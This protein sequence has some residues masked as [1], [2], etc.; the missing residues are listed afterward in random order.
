[1]DSRV[2]RFPTATY[3]LQL[4]GQLRFEKVG[5]LADYL[6]ELGIGAAYLS[7][8]FRAR[9]GSTHGYDVVDHRQPDPELGTEEDFAAMAG[10]L[11]R[12]GMGLMV[13]IVPNHMG[14]DDPH[15]VWWQDVL[16]NGPSSI[17]AKYFD[18][19]WNP[20]K[21]ALRGKV[22]LPAL[23][24]QFGKVL[25]E[26]QLRLTYED[27]RLVVR[28]YDRT[29]PTD[30]Q[31][32]VPLL[33]QALEFVGTRLAPEVEERME[34]ESIITAL[35]HLPRRSGR[36]AEL[37]Q[38]R[39]RETEVARRRLSTLMSA[40]EDVRLGVEQAIEDY[41]GQR[42]VSASFD[43]LES[44]LTEQA[45]RLCYWRV[46]TD[47][48]NYRRFFDVDA[49]AA[50]R[51]EEPEVFEAVHE[52]ILR[53]I[54]A[55][56]VTALRIDHADGLFD[57]QQ[58]LSDLADAVAGVRKDARPSQ[59]ASEGERLYTVVEKILAYDESLPSDWPVH[60]TTGYDFLNLLGGIFVDRLGAY[61]LRD[62]YARFTERSDTFRDVL[63]QSKRTILATSLSAELYMLSQ[64][65]D[66]ISEQHRWSRDFT[67][68]SLF[69]ALREV[70]TCFPVY[71]TYIRPESGEVREEDRR[72]ILEAI[73][74]AKRRNPAMSPSFFDFIAAV[75]LLEEPEGLSE[76]D[77]RERQRFVRKFQQFTG[78]VTAKGLEDTSFY[79]YFPL[80]SLNEVGGDPSLPGISIEQ[81]HRRIL[82]QSSSWPHSMLASGTH[83]TKRGED[84]RARL[85]VLAEIPDAWE[86][87]IK[88]WHAMNAGSRCELDGAPVPDANEEYL[89]YQTL[90]GSWPVEMPDEAGRVEYV[91]RIVHYLDK[92]LRE[93][94][95]HTS[96]LNPYEE[97]DQGVA[98]FIRSILGQLDTPFAN[99]VGLFAR[100]IAEAGF[101]NSLAQTLVKMCAPGVPDVYQ[102][103]EFWDF[104]LVDP[105]NR[106]PVDFD[107]RR[108]ALRWLQV[109]GREGLGDVAAELMARWPD[110]RLK[111]FMIWQ[112][113]QHRGSHRSLLEGTYQPLFAEGPRKAQLCA[114]ARVAQ[115]DWALCIV[116]RLVYQATREV[117]ESNG[118]SAS[119]SWALASWW[120]DTHLQLPAEA[121]RRWRHVLTGHVIDA[122]DTPE[123]G[124]TLDLAQV[125]RLFPVALLAGEIT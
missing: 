107:C 52:T 93:A 77:R 82:E 123:G 86:A 54:A 96:W 33:R 57:P 37:L 73:R 62:I 89:I 64:R 70:V 3:R 9:H 22:L 2:T 6:S 85:N 50:I 101:V 12:Q 115:T 59:A 108:K 110:K 67:R 61:A 36:T 117:E 97:Y 103:V 29:F 125:L 79:R 60:G 113:L 63:H 15:N 94:K 66:R 51:V 32:W 88:R 102:G 26:Q 55:G 81:F 105:D 27:Q 78:P 100:S 1:V 11:R 76:D 48:I 16:E 95:L 13:D 68:F 19:D 39:H 114:F 14:I 28:Y 49:L 112:S 35:E 104:N 106:R 71:R 47:E 92:A 83:D 111:L 56:W 34:L 119:G 46:A 45:Y 20:P 74:T 8:F 24:D 42:G 44:L 4:S 5:E 122:V 10:A 21:E 121:P 23:G 30:P 118:G 98:S 124:R 40:S 7:P 109:R 58:Y 120:Q 18:I 69:R 41:N 43:K 84:L 72:R 17:Y 87:A 25:E 91:E 80:A 65:L 53:F 116:P 75:L 90:V 38:E 99:D 31:T